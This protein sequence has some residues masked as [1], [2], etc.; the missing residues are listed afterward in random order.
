MRELGTK[1]SR[2][3]ALAGGVCATASAVMG[4]P[5]IAKSAPKIVIIGGGPGGATV[6]GRVKEAV[7]TA[8]V[9]LIEAQAQYASC[10]FSNHFIGGRLGF[11]KL[12]HGYEGLRALG[13]GVINARAEHIDLA[14]RSVRIAGGD[15]VSYDLLVVAP[16]I[17]FKLGGVEGLTNDTF[18][19]MPH[20]W[21]GGAQAQLLRQQLEAMRDGGTVLITAPKLQYRCPPGPYER[22]CFIA[23]YL[24]REKP[25]SKIIILDAKFSFAKQAVF[26]EGYRTYYTG[27]IEHLLTNDIDDMD[28][29]SVDVR[30]RSVTT[31]SG[32]RFAGDVVNLVP[33]QCAGH[34]ARDA[35]LADPDWCPVDVRSFKSTLAKDV[36][37]LG[38]ASV[39][40]AMP[41]SAFSA[42]NQAYVVVEAI[43]AQL[44]GRDMGPVGYR[45]TCWSFIAPDNSVKI[46]ADY[47]PGE[48]NGRMSLIP[49]DSFI[50]ARAEKAAIRKETYDESFVWHAELVRDVF[51]E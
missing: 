23:D 21:R 49:K 20:A 4:I 15:A 31:R 3:V 43:K 12:V 40:S 28:I 48:K 26:E 16:G 29:A 8:S 41:K 34:I 5:A 13:V 36:F 19:V 33:E 38:D 11:D 9:M 46:G 42:N 37:I 1:L 7:G 22:A 27:K 2:R 47:V 45:N 18:S 39:G 44:K 50:S 10:F 32:E 35:G 30:E 51:R 6:A 17:D 14:R 24:K 25:K